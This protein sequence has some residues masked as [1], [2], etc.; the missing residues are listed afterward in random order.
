MNARRHVVDVGIEKSV[1]GSM[2][3]RRRW[4]WWLAA[5]AAAVSAHGLVPPQQHCVAWTPTTKATSKPANKC[6]R[7][8]LGVPGRYQYDEQNGYCGEVALQQLMLAHG[9]W[10]PQVV[11]R[12]AGGGEL[13][14]GVNYAKALD[15]LGVEYETFHGKGYDAFA[16]WA[17]GCLKRGLG[18]VEAAF[19]KGGSDAEY[20]HLMPIVGLDECPGDNDAFFVN[21]GYATR[22]VRRRV[23]GYSCA[24]SNKKNSIDEAGCV[25]TNTRWGHAIRGP[26][27]A[28]IGPPV[29][30][31]VDQSR[32]PGPRKPGVRFT[33]TLTIRGL[34][35]GVTYRVL[36]FTDPKT[37]PKDAGHR[38]AEFVAYADDHQLS[39]SF[40][41]AMP[42]YY[43]CVAVA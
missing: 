6:A 41:S 24:A 18:V 11:A 29:S 42:S 35:P 15:N 3:K 36:R 21:T 4:W 39:V 2:G 27:Y 40:D 37:V 1:H 25:P 8:M 9:V 38:V 30:L 7:T 5:I 14:L 22:P 32:E 20:D 13:L 19:F 26:V 23:A 10:I 16:T 34:T 33:G 12:K 31:R 17:K 28:G 43:V